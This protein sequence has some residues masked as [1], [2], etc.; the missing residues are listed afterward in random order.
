LNSATLNSIF[1]FLASW[2]E[3]FS[4]PKSWGDEDSHGEQPGKGPGISPEIQPWSKMRDPLPNRLIEGMHRDLN[5]GNPM[6]YS[7]DQN[8]H[9]KLV[10][11]GSGSKVKDLR[12]GVDS[13]SRLAIGK[14]SSA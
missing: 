10:S 4:S 6:P 1:L 5:D 7:P 3:V 13:Q 11:P 8:L 2:F 9:L 12:E 14:P